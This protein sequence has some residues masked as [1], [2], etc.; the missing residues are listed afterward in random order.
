MAFSSCFLSLG[1]AAELAE[2]NRET[3]VNAVANYSTQ[4]TNV[5]QQILVKARTGLF[6]NQYLPTATE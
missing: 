5:A 1:Y 6:G 4:M 3:I 2:K